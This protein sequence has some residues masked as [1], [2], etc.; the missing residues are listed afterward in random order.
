M[1]E[2]SDKDLDDA[3]K[4]VDRRMKEMEAKEDADLVSKETHRKLQE[5]AAKDEEARKKKDK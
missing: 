3:V 1:T 2:P 4:D 5:R